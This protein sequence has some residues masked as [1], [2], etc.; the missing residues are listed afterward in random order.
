MET[1]DCA[2]CWP[3]LCR[4]MYQPKGSMC[5][6]CSKLDQD[7]SGYDFSKMPRIEECEDGTVKVRCLHY[8]KA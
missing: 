6:Q 7:C 2:P 8:E 1:F 4:C 3:K 5:M